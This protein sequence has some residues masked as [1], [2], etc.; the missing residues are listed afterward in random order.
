M[1]LSLVDAAEL[2]SQVTA[3]LADGWSLVGP[4]QVGSVGDGRGGTS[5]LHVATLTR[6]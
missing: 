2:E 6:S 5:W 3:A 4:V 1:I